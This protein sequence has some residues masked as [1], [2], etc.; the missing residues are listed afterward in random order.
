MCISFAS[1][2]V[3]ISNSSTLSYLF[4]NNNIR[5]QVYMVLEY[6]LFNK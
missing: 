2:Q 6:G 3:Y 5:K 4:G 1:V